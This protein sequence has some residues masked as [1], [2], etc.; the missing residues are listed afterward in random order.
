MVSVT[1][2]T[3]SLDNL[4][5]WNWT[6]QKFT[7]DEYKAYIGRPQWKTDII[8]GRQ[9]ESYEEYEAY[10]ND[11]VKTWLEASRNAFG[12]VKKEWAYAIR[13]FEKFTER[14]KEVSSA[15]A[16]PAATNLPFLQKALIE[17]VAILF[18]SLPRPQA[19]GRQASEDDLIGALN[20]YI[21]E[22]CDANNF[23]MTMYDIGLDIQLCNL[24]VL[25]QTVDMD[26]QGP[27]G[28]QGEIV[29]TRVE[30]RYIHPDPLAGKLEWKSMKY[31]IVAEPCDL[32]DIRLKYKELGIFVEAESAYT[33]T[34]SDEDA[35]ESKGIADSQPN[36]IK[37][38][39]NYGDTILSGKVRQ[40]A[41]LKECWFKDASLVFVADQA[42]TTKDKDGIT[43]MSDHPWA[44]DDEGYVKGQ[45]QARYPDGRLIVIANGVLLFDGENPFEHGRPP[46]AFFRGRPSS[47]VLSPGDASFLIVIE[48]KLN[49]IYSRIYNMAQ[50]N[51]E[52]PT[53]VDRNAFD[54]P[55]KWRNLDTLPMTIIPVTPGANLHKLEAGEIPSFVYPLASY[56]ENFFEDFMGVQGV[57]RGKLAEGAQLSAQALG[58]LQSAQG[59]RTRMKARFIEFG[60]KEVGEQLVSNIVSTY[61]DGTPAKVTDPKDGQNYTV[62]WD[63]DRAGEDFTIVIQAGSSL[64]GSKQSA[65]EQ[66]LQLYRE[67]IVDAQYVLETAQVPNSDKILQRNQMQLQEAI[68]AQA[69]G[70][71]VGLEIKQITKPEDT[72]GRKGMD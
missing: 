56:L 43:E 8:D 62:K 72:A 19:Q 67:K 70:R 34:R 53:I 52:R 44:I 61:P 64:P 3:S 7:P 28:H 39:A 20:Y 35:G 49:D 29:M 63:R 9:F 23:D 5:A 21:G 48:R 11:C 15:K 10:W 57:A 14:M 58:D 47:G 16:D 22:E 45:W 33:T 40:R 25:K 38:P 55:A 31:L 37:S 54:S 13:R 66:A 17:L 4:D 26:G 36:V 60:L 41:L 32:T 12:K 65:F 1:E 71:A 27:F 42:P 30:P 18:D 2:E 69:A 51:I 46:Y 68:A 50:A 59:T 24:G 6:K